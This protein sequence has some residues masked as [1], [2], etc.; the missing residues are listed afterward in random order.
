MNIKTEDSAA[1]FATR[2]VTRE[3]NLIARNLACLGAKRAAEAT[4]THILDYWEPRLR[5]ALLA[6]AVAHPER[7]SPIASDAIARLPAA[8]PGSS[9]PVERCPGA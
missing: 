5:S 1:S 9:P 2:R 4:A 8:Q 6:E 3:C 7:F